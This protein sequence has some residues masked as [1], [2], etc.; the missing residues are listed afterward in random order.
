MRRSTG[1][2]FADQPSL[3]PWPWPA[4]PT[5]AL[6]RQTRVQHRGPRQRNGLQ[7]R[8]S[9]SRKPRIAVCAI[10]LSLRGQRG[11]TVPFGVSLSIACGKTAESFSA[12]SCGETPAF[13]ANCWMTSAPKAWCTC[14]AEMA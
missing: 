13:A 10:A 1:L 4:S 11:G 14:A 7:T 6:A 5:C 12:S 3:L 8:K 2:L 9:Y